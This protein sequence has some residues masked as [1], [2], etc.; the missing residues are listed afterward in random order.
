MQKVWDNLNLRT[1][2][3]YQRANDEYSSSNLDW[4]ASLWIQDRINANHMESKEGIS[5][6]N[7]SDLNIMDFVASAKEKDYIFR[8]MIRFFAHRLVT[9]HPLLFKTIAGSIKS[10]IPHQFQETMDGKSAEFTGNLF[11][12]SESSTEDLITM[13]IDVQ[14]Y[15]N[16]FKDDHDV[17]HSYE[18]KI[19]SGDN[20]TEKNMHH[21]I[22]SKTDENSEED[23]LG[24]I[25]PAHE[26]FHQ[27]M[28]VA[29]CEKEL[30]MD[31]S[32]GLEGGAFF[33]ATLL[34]RKDVKT[35]K[36][37]DAIDS[38]KDFIL[39]KA[40]AR[41]CQYLLHKFDLDP[42]V[43]NTPDSIK[44]ATHN[45]KE[46]FVHNY[47][48]EALRDLLPYF[49]DCSNEDPHLVDHPLQEG[50]RDKYQSEREPARRVDLVETNIVVE[51]HASQN[52][53]E[54]LETHLQEMSLN[55]SGTRSK[56]MY[57]CGICSFQTRYRTVCLTHIKACL[58]QNEETND[59]LEE[60]PDTNQMNDMYWNY[61]NC[62][63]MLDAI[64]SITDLFERFG[65]GLGCYIVNKIL[66]PVFH[67]LR[68]SNYTNS[69]HRFITRVLCEATP[70]EAL[71]LIHEKFSNRSG[72]PGKNINRDKRMEYR[73]GTAKK[74][75]GN[76]GPN[77]SPEAVQQVNKT[78]GVKEE[79]FLTARKSHGVAIRNDLDFFPLLARF[80]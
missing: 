13:M 59:I 39:L 35:Q 37:K 69:I 80:I 56:T 58:L 6:K 27:S 61:K 78:L 21:G 11:T 60:N 15:V 63:F 52:T 49:R 14:K 51:E 43:D 36:A 79:L 33:A 50:R 48:E 26:Y 23:R 45:E 20:K 1:K 71:K 3:R 5:V 75:I 18:R 9:R 40:D 57:K 8:A 10:N 66:L 72:K 68:H 46:A 34:N 12:K 41:F 29:D 2:H 30:F 67:G 70:K 16:K 25:L 65:D 4:M 55:L 62:E 24:F 64:F 28:V 31:N 47:V 73:I 44:R 32:R 53:E 54:M 76:L 74:L 42:A 17:V 22:L 19:V 38:M 7:V 77:F